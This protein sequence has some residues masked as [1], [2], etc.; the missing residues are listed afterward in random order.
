MGRTPLALLNNADFEYSITRSHCERTICDIP[1]I[2]VFEIFQLTW[3][4]SP[5]RSA[6]F[7]NLSSTL[8]ALE[9]KITLRTA[10]SSSLTVTL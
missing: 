4:M 1:L 8:L 10:T 2:G 5:G 9:L 7:A 6:F 3:T